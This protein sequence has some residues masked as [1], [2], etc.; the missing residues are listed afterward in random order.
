MSIPSR[1]GKTLEGDLLRSCAGQTFQLRALTSGH[2]IGLVKTEPLTYE[3]RAQS[4]GRN[5]LGLEWLGSDVAMAIAESWSLW[6]SCFVCWIVGSHV[7]T[8]NVWIMALDIDMNQSQ[9]ICKSWNASLA[10]GMARLVHQHPS[11]SKWEDEAAT[12]FSA[13]LV[14]QEIYRQGRLCWCNMVQHGATFKF[15]AYLWT[16]GSWDF[17]RPHAYR[18]LWVNTKHP[19]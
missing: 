13:L 8:L 5:E 6:K 15:H 17:Q 3:L 11:R 7:V 2:L 10:F 4:P 19:G 1:L 18:W 9:F 14:H 12:L 16:L